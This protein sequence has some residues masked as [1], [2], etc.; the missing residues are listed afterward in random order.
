MSSISSKHFFAVLK[1]L[2]SHSLTITVEFIWMLMVLGRVSVAL[3]L[4]K[5]GDSLHRLGD[6]FL[7]S[8]LGMRIYRWT[9]AGSFNRI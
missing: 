3:G 2:N 9:G 8:P 1:D 5:S 6:S 4:L 7:A